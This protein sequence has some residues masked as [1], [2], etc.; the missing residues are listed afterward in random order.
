M[1]STAKE[2]CRLCL[3]Q[4]RELSEEMMLKARKERGEAR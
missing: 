4:V 3:S 2:K 1:W